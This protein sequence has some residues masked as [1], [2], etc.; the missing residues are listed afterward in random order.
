MFSSVLLLQVFRKVTVQNA[1][2]Q[3]PAHTPHSDV[4]IDVDVQVDHRLHCQQAQC[5][6][7]FTDQK[8]AMQ[9]LLQI[10][11]VSRQ[12]FFLQPNLVFDG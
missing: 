1:R 11:S 2:A 6:G 3:Q 7:S 8:L 4:S 9:T 5:S 12:S 10:S